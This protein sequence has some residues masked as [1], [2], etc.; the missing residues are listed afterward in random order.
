MYRHAYLYVQMCHVTYIINIS[1]QDIHRCGV[2]N[3]VVLINI[4]NVK[5]GWLN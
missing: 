2:I 1:M 4:V 3:M 5:T